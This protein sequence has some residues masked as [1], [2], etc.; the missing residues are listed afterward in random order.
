MAQDSMSWEYPQK[1]EGECWK[2]FHKSTIAGVFHNNLKCTVYGTLL[3]MLFW[4]L[5]HITTI[6]YTPCSSVWNHRL[7]SLALE[8]WYRSLSF[9]GPAFVALTVTATFFPSSP[10][11]LPTPPP[12]PPTQPLQGLTG[13]QLE[14]MKLIGHFPQVSIP[15]GIFVWNLESPVCGL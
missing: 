4:D 9:F 5:S 6:Q 11:L 12:S 1:G 15:L 7:S 3:L 8:K 2:L 13:R 10:P 14:I